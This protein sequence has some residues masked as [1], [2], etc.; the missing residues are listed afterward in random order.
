MEYMMFLPEWHKSRL[1]LIRLAVTRFWEHKRYFHFTNQGIHHSE[2]VHR[3]LSELIGELP[4][5]Q[6]LGIEE[7]FILLAA[8]WLYE[9]GMQ[10]PDLG[11]I[12]NI[13][14]NKEGPT[15]SQ[16]NTIRASKHLLSQRLI[17]GNF[18]DA[19]RG[20]RIA[21]GLNTPMDQYTI[22]IAEVCRWCSNEPLAEVPETG[23]VNGATVRIRLIV[24][25]LRLADQLYIDSPRINFDVLDAAELSMS[26]FARWWAYHYTSILPIQSGQINFQYLLPPSQKDYLSQIR[27]LIE[28]EFEFDNNHTIQYLSE[29]YHLRLLPPR[30]PII[31]PLGPPISL[32]PM[33]KKLL[34]FLK[35]RKDQ[36]FSEVSSL[37][38]SQLSVNSLDRVETNEKTPVPGSSNSMDDY[39]SD[40]VPSMDYSPNEIS[41]TKV[42]STR[43]EQLR[44][45]LVGT[46]FLILLI[47]VIFSLSDLGGVTWFSPVVNWLIRFSDPLLALWLFSASVASI[48]WIVIFGMLQIGGKVS[49]KSSGCVDFESESINMKHPVVLAVF[50]IP[51]WVVAVLFVCSAFGLYLLRPFCQVP[52]IVF[53]AVGENEIITP[54]QIIKTGTDASLIL[55]AWDAD[56]STQVLRCRWTF[57]GASIISLGQ[58]SSCTTTV[59]FSNALS[60]SS[61]SVKASKD[62][63]DTY[64]TASVVISRYP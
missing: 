43:F 57:D 62:F 33:D 21:L 50:G 32:R 25:L 5:D 22:L 54:G 24:A 29:E 26:E 40:K 48:I 4:Q 13:G 11:A 58:P 53:Q 16:L 60:E 35:Q 3:I 47:L 17:L 10:S 49:I 52:T 39:P 46:S 30:K 55:K 45:Y 34:L 2:R 23:L 18:S 27:N 7:V 37:T 42:D 31:N 6:R 63:C 51:A 15:H 64:T 1:E 12:P 8:A 28:S 41:S 56:D 44:A 20:N 59:Y 61:I 36:L 9:I 19:Y 14:A 38:D